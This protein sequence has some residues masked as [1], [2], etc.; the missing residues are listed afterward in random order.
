MHH[1][2]EFLVKFSLR[3]NQ[4]NNCTF[5]A[6]LITYVAGLKTDDYE[7]IRTRIKKANKVKEIT[8]NNKK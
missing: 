7:K 8:R 2:F 5:D 4:K 3:I 6:D 1:K